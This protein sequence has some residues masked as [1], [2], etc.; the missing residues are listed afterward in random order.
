MLRME[1]VVRRF[2]PLTA[3]D[4]IS[5]EVP[6]G[7]VFALAGP[8]GAGKSTA[9]KLCV[10]LLR[11][12]SGRV[13]VF[14][15]D[16]CRLGPSQ[17]ARIGYVSE[18]R[19]LPDWMTLSAW[20]AYLKPFYPDWH[21]GDLAELMRI[22][23][24]P[25]H[26]PLRSLSRGMRMQAALCAALAYR[27]RL[28]LLDE[29][30]SGLDVLVR[31]QLIETLAARSGETTVVLASHDLAE[32][33]SFATHVAYLSEGRLRFVEEIGTLSS[34]FR[35]IEVVLESP[36]AALPPELPRGWLNLE[37]LNRTVRFVHSRYQASHAESEIRAHFSDVHDV[38]VSALPLRSIFAALAKAAATT[39]P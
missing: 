21:D 5:L 11:P 15:V 23:Q 26:R 9:L 38:T 2:G 17:L 18:H 20:F 28:L 24:L 30:F 4:E 12:T 22:Y 33:E 3:L 13:E 32:I 8:N 35:E 16:S 34:R 10:N 29:P 31:D 19:H 37:R 6:A 25:P 14:D 1:A 27:P 7:S 39:R 36:S